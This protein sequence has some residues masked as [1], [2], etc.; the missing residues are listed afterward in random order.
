MSETVQLNSIVGT[1]AL[2]YN[3]TME[4]TKTIGILLEDLEALAPDA[5]EYLHLFLDDLASF[6][7]AG[8]RDP[9]MVKYS[10]PSIE[11]DQNEL[12]SA[13]DKA[14]G[15]GADKNQLISILSAIGGAIQLKP[16]TYWALK[17]V[18]KHIGVVSSN[19]EEDELGQEHPIRFHT[20]NL[21]YDLRDLGLFYR[22]CGLVEN[23]KAGSGSHRKWE[24]RDGSFSIVC[25]QN[26]KKWLKR[27][28][29][30]M[31]KQGFPVEKVATAC[32][33]LGIDFQVINV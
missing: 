8:Y 14:V 22:A 6:D 33:S 11:D 29:D 32:E 26:G 17:P 3:S 15:L 10:L 2:W 5:A 1:I 4:K 16:V 20:P 30:Q 27:V 25:S 12:I 21:L 31:L 19:S 24:A 7:V 13:F 28:I 9:D 18:L 23:T